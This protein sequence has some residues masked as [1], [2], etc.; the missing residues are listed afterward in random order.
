MYGPSARSLPDAL[1]HCGNWTTETGIFAFRVSPEAR[2]ILD[3]CETF[4]DEASSSAVDAASIDRFRAEARKAAALDMSNLDVV[5]TLGHGAFGRVKLVT[6]TGTG[7]HYALKV[8]RKK[9]LLD[10]PKSREQLMSD[11]ALLAK[12]REHKRNLTVA[13][14][15]AALEYYETENRVMHRDGVIHGI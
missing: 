9:Q 11:R 6:H 15:S 14:F 10:V 13:A 4:A 8:V 2:G 5:K 1:L 3:A 7:V 12:C